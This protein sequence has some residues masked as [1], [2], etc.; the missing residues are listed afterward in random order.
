[1][2]TVMSQKALNGRFCWRTILLV[3]ELFQKFSGKG[4]EID[5]PLCTV[6]VQEVPVSVQTFDGSSYWAIEY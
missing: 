1:M 6:L 4:G 3:K 2:L 5:S